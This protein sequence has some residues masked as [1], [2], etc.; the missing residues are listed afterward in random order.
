MDR[1][2]ATRSQSIAAA[3]GAQTP[4]R[5][6]WGMFYDEDRA[7]AAGTGSSGFLW[8]DSR[9]ALLEYAATYLAYVG[10]EP[11]LGWEEAAARV[12]QAV[13][14]LVGGRSDEAAALAEINE[15]LRG[16][17]QL[18][19]WGPFEDILTGDGAFPRLV[20][21]W[22]FADDDEPGDDASSDV[23]PIEPEMI[24][25]FADDIWQYGI[26]LGEG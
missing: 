26:Q 19:W 25:D 20:R 4:Q 10:A 5:S 7:G 9:A 14:A 23:P 13:E 16:C 1:R 15:H 11:H 6:S 21:A 8:F 22:W 17:V 12:R 24:D 2:I 18:L 3:A